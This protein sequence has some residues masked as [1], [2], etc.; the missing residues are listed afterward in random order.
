MPRRSA[1][2]ANP[3]GDA[4]TPEEITTALKEIAA[5]SKKVWTTIQCKKCWKEGKYEVEVSDDKT[6]LQA[7]QFMHEN[8]YGRPSQARDDGPKIALDIDITTLTPEARGELRRK[9][10]ALNPNLPKAWA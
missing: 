8:G 5:S 9:L 1:T 7:I 4:L 10:L 6:R 2:V 3:A